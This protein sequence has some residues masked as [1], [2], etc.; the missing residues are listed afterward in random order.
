MTRPLVSNVTVLVR[1]ASYPSPLAGE[2]AGEG[3]PLHPETKPPG[4]AGRR[5][6]SVHCPGLLSGK[7]TGQDHAVRTST[8]SCLKEVQCNGNE[9]VDSVAGGQTLQNAALQS[10]TIG[11]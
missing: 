7:H 11:T 1:P 9:A 3:E 8:T 10:V 5:K 2:G 4:R 6:S